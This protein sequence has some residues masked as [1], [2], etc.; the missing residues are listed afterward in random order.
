MFGWIKIRTV[1]CAM[2]DTAI[3]PQTMSKSH[4]CFT[5]GVVFFVLLLN[6]SLGFCF[7]NPKDMHFRIGATEQWWNL[8]QFCSS[9]IFLGYFPTIQTNL[10]GL[11]PAFFQ[12]G[13]WLQSHHR[14][15][16]LPGDGIAAFTL[17]MLGNISSP[18]PTIQLGLFSICSKAFFY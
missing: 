13:G 8:N 9:Y 11:C 15:I 10:I 6:A 12:Q 16:K 3:L 4:S 5:V 18:L 2:Q 14:N 7:I 17:I 1:P